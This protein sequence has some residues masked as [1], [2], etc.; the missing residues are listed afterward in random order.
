MDIY[1]PTWS[2]GIKATIAKALASVV[3]RNVSW[4]LGYM[5]MEVV[6]RDC[7]RSLNDLLIHNQSKKISLGLRFSSILSN[8]IDKYATIFWRNLHFSSWILQLSVWIVFQTFLYEFR[9][10]QGVFVL[11]RF[12]R[13]NYPSLVGM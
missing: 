9:Q 12:R 3:N 10:L 7:F 2:W 5:I 11:I 4:K 13:S 1:F 6:I 8:K